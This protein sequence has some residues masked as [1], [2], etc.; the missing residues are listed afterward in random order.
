MMNYYMGMISFW[1]FWS[2]YKFGPIYLVRFKYMFNFKSFGCVS[3]ECW[4]NAS[5]LP[6]SSCLLAGKETTVTMW[7]NEYSSIKYG[8]RL[9]STINNQKYSDRCWICGLP[10]PAMK[11]NQNAEV[12][13]ALFRLLR[14]GKLA[15]AIRRWANYRDLHPEITLKWYSLV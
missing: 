1:H 8:F 14:I 12:N 9:K 11:Q 4:V 3:C 6:I 7:I 15:R 13:A 2:S 10:S 5:S